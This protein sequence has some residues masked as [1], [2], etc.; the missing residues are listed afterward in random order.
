MALRV[1][2]NYAHAMMRADWSNVA[3]SLRTAV[4][5]VQCLAIARCLSLYSLKL[6][7]LFFLSSMSARSLVTQV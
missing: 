1:A 3:M 2:M 4:I 5:G 7:L 6:R